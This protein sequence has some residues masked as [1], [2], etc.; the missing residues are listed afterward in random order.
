MKK[1]MKKI[2]YVQGVFDLFH[3]GHLNLLKNAKSQCD[4]LIVAVN[5]DELV[6][7]YKN[8]T[9]IIPLKE[10]IEIV[11]AIRYVDKVVIAND[12]DKIKAFEKYHFDYLM[13]G[14]DWKN[15]P[16]YHE[17][18]KK[19]NAIGVKIIYFPYTKHTSSTKL[20]KVLDEIIYSQ[21]RNKEENNDQK[22]KKTDE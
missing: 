11:K 3:I 15:T 19:L 21:S 20:S 22:I 4:Y 12:R 18:E 9:P 1:N 2:G 7:Q 5:T 13:M 8:K 10:R 6:E 16:F 14:D 17:Y